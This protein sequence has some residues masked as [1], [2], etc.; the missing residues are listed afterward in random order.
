M[1]LAIHQPQFMPWSGYFHKM[2]W[3][4][5]FVLLDNVQFK[6]NE[7]QHRNRIKGP[8]GPQWLSVP[9][10]YKFP[11]MVNEVGVADDHQWRIKHLRSIENNY[12]RSAFFKE[13]FPRFEAFYAKELY[14]LCE[15]SIASITLLA[16]CLGITT[17]LITASEFTVEGASTERLLNICRHLG[18][19]TYLAGAGGKGY[20]NM[21]LFAASGITVAFQEY[22]PPRYPQL[23]CKTDG[24]FV[25]GLSVIDLLFNCGP[26]SYAVLMKGGETQ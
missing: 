18:A 13:Y 10:T 11:Q 1:N 20:M 7:W 25:A 4:D 9:N 6:K 12:R 19:D 5:T 23:F 8:N 2:A 17:P 22:T 26:D 16:E 15:Y 24:D 3:C 21:D 14:T